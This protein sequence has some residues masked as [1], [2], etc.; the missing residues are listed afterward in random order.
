MEDQEEEEVM[1]V[2]LSPSSPACPVRG[3]LLPW[4][5]GKSEE[6]RWARSPWEKRGEVEIEEEGRERMHA[7]LVL[8]L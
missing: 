4:G 7:P 2:P 8:Q 6:W 3:V 1:V 5:G